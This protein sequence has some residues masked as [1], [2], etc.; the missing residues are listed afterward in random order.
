[1]HLCL[2]S[3]LLDNAR[4]YAFFN[5]SVTLGAHVERDRIAIWVEDVGSE[6]PESLG[7]SIHDLGAGRSAGCA[8]SVAVLTGVA[9]EV[10]LAPEA[11]VV[12]P[13]IADLPDFLTRSANP[14]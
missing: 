13:S 14:T 2:S 3:N 4:K 8:Y 5:R 11:D 9:T 10:E 1:M 12:L 6:V 7:D